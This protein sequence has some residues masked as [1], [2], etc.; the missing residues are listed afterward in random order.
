MS[1][2]EKIFSG[3]VRV[4]FVIAFAAF[5][6]ASLRHIAVFF[7]SYEPAGADGW[8]SYALAWSIDGTALVLTI[9]L[10]FF[11]KRMG[12]WS[13]V[14]VWFFVV[15]LTGFSWLVN[16]EY[17]ATFQS[18]TLTSHL[19]PA[20]ADIN[21]VLASSFAFL[22]MAYSIIAEVFSSRPPTIEELKAEL[23]G[24]T[25][26]A[27]TLKK[28]IAEAKG[29]GLIDK[30]KEAA[31]KAKMAAAEVS[32]AGRQDSEISAPVLS[33][34]EQE[35]FDYVEQNQ[36][37]ERLKTGGTFYP[38]TGPISEQKS[39]QNFSQF[40]IETGSVFHPEIAADLA[41]DFDENLTSEQDENGPATDPEISAPGA[42][43]SGEFYGVELPA[44]PNEDGPPTTAFEAI[45]GL[46][47]N[48]E[49]TPQ[50][51]DNNQTKEDAPPPSNN[52]QSSAPASPAP[53][54]KTT[55][56]TYRQASRLEI[57]Q[58]KGVK[59]A[60]IRAAVSSRKLST[61]KD[62]SV[63]KSGVEN[64][65]KTIEKKQPAMNGH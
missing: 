1:T 17:A 24:L 16:W 29:P 64:W 36:G 43:D 45:I 25:G 42:P 3:A 44:D 31:I 57:C 7:Q 28:R 21:P 51:P 37:Q 46:K 54:K 26:E 58:K 5:L 60:D 48:V 47:G 30:A 23:D 55:G 4:V 19:P 59:A 8:G 34:M 65:A 10:M 50:N 27:A 39:G 20:F 52:A 62:G 40:S 41:Q 11:G 9:G 35:F 14:F 38:N 22:N 56:L 61:F 18:A 53:E 49:F 32:A 33:E 6:L 63:S 15:A 2:G 12:A 13:K